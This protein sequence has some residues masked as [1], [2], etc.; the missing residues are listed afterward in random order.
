MLAERCAHAFPRKVRVDH[1]HV[2]D[3]PNNAH[4]RTQECQIAPTQRQRDRGRREQL[5]YSKVRYEKLRDYG[6][7]QRALRLEH[8]T[9]LA[10][11]RCYYA[12]AQFH[13]AR[14][15]AEHYERIAMA[16]HHRDPDFHQH[17]VAAALAQA[18][19]LRNLAR[20]GN[21]GKP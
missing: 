6:C 20:A 15:L 9:H 10:F 14:Q 18:H 5:N 4:G 12:G 7:A 16:L 19:A 8:D 3:G 21:R 1:A 11:P 2:F 13:E 17:D